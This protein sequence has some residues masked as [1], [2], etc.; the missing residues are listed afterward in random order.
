L[1]QYTLQ[2][3]NTPTS[4]FLNPLLSRLQMKLELRA[5]LTLENLPNH[6]TITL[7]HR[8]FIEATLATT[9]TVALSAVVHTALDEI[10]RLTKRTFTS[11]HPWL[12]PMF[13]QHLLK[14]HLSPQLDKSE[15]GFNH[16][17]LL[18]S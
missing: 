4:Q 17:M 8:T 11:V 9:A 14:S 18:Q 6:Q 15:I 16:W 3:F 7:K 1:R 2:L 5:I 13:N 12:M 10:S